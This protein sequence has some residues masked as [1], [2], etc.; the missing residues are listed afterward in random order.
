VQSYLKFY[1]RY[2]KNFADITKPFIELTKEGTKWSWED[3]HQEAF[4]KSKRV[5]LEKVI[6]AFPHFKKP[7]YI[8]VDASN[9][10]IGGELYQI[11]KDNERATLGY[12]SRTLKPAET[13]Y[14][15][16]EIVALAVVYCS[17]FGQY[18]LGSKTIIQTDHQA[19]TF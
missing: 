8:N 4:V 17:K 12:A 7:M 11:L 18:I 13:R 1:R 5:F 19:L 15:T 6:I 3:K 9:V 14:T 2:I 10:A 16:T